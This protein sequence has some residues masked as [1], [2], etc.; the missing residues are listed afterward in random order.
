MDDK[1]LEDF[2]RDLSNKLTITE[3]CL[4]LNGYS[5]DSIFDE[6]KGKADISVVKELSSK[7]DNQNVQQI[8][9]LREIAETRFSE[10]A[11]AFSS[12][13]QI[14]LMSSLIAI[15]SR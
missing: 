1:L 10:M 8:Q 13:V 4:L 2:L 7:L 5:R 9:I 11:T 3:I 12:M 14:A 6:I 15:F